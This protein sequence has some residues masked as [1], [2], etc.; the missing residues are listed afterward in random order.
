MAV[1][2]PL[3]GIEIVNRYLDFLSLNKVL[4]ILDDQIE[5]IGIRMIEVVLR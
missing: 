5:I 4:K 3:G 2:L 1:S